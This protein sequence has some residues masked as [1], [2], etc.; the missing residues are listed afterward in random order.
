MER[1]RLNYI[2]NSTKKCENL[3]SLYIPITTVIINKLADTWPWPPN[4]DC[5]RQVSL[6]S[7]YGTLQVAT[8]DTQ[9]QS[10]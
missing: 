8:T 3:I 10:N 5:S 9:I 7:W 1:K 6:E 4:K 2:S